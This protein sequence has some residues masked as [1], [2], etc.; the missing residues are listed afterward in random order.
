[1]TS[2]IETCLKTHSFAEI[3]INYDKEK[4]LFVAQLCG[5]LI[6]CKDPIN[7]LFF[8]EEELKTTNHKQI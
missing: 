2:A 8:L 6:T 5:A 4:D 7:I 1:M 3:L